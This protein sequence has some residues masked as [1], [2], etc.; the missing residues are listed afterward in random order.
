VEASV[1]DYDLIVVGAGP[2]GTSAAIT[3]AQ[4]G[5]KVLLLERGSFPRHRVCGEFVSAESLDLLSGLLGSDSEAL[6]HSSIAI[7]LARVFLDGQLIKSRIQPAA[8]SIA[9]FDLDRALWNSAGHKGVELRDRVTVKQIDPSKGAGFTIS[10]TDGEFHARAVIDA[11][12]RWSNINRIPL[13]D[14]ARFVG[15][16]GHF[17]EAEP[18]R[19]V[20]LYFFDGGYCGV[21]PVALH[22]SNDSRVNACALVRAD[23]AI[24]LSDIFPLHSSLHSRSRGWTSLMDEVTT[25]PLIFR[26]P[27]PI[28]DGLMAVGDAAGFVD[29]FVGDGISLALRS[30]AL[31]A[32]CL[33]DTDY[34]IAAQQLYAKRYE[35]ELAPIYRASSTLRTLLKLPTAIRKPALALLKSSPKLQQFIVTRTRRAG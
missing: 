10:S 13:G 11:S 21:Q 8:A 27:R 14:E 16:K 20:D 35:T 12:G 2:G 17:T 30:G 6:V 5:A 24:S 19:S 22:G 28:R 18:S 9:R 26:D 23:I 3:S 34:G 33:T 1:T 7:P 29:P 4:L 15:I 32:T 25:S 31:A